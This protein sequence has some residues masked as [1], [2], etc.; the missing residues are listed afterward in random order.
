MAEAAA[1][2]EETETAA[3]AAEAEVVGATAGTAG[4]RR[5]AG[6]GLAAVVVVVT[7]AANGEGPVF[8]PKDANKDKPDGAERSVVC[9][10]TVAVV[11]VDTGRGSII[12]AKAANE[13]RADGPE[14][15]AAFGSATIVAAATSGD[16]V[17]VLV[18]M[19]ESAAMAE[20]VEI[21]LA[22]SF[23]AVAVIVV[24]AMGSG[25]AIVDIDASI[26]TAKGVV[27][28]ITGSVEPSW[29]VPRGD[30]A[31]SHGDVVVPPAPTTRT[32][33]EALGVAKAVAA[34]VVTG[35]ERTSEV[36]TA[37]FV[38]ATGKSSAAEG[39]GAGPESIGGAT[40]GGEAVLLRLEF[41]LPL[42]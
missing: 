13:D 23:V 31:T 17:S 22:C 3:V 32:V 33:P 39:L 36:D 2:E 28:V 9:G 30:S 34:A 26:E 12:A 42:V 27:I 10:S 18:D 29:A 5:S 1:E 6:C 4:E 38:V 40:E 7:V 11:V 15:S 20:G 19:D 25:P 8:S 21:P 16:S 37:V 24:A 14:G 41:M 35:V